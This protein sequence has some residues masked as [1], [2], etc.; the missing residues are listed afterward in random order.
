M[1]WIVGMQR[2]INY[3]EEHLTEDVDFESV[4]KESFSSV[5]HFQR[6]FSLLCGYTLGE[7]IRLRRLSLAGTEL[8]GGKARVI[9]VAL[10][11]GYDSPDSFAKAFQ[12]FHGITPSEARIDGKVLKSF[13]RLSIKISLEGGSAMNYR[14]E[15]K[16]AFEIIERAEI[17]STENGENL[18]T[19]PDFWARAGADGTIERL[20]KLTNDDKY[21][22]GICYGTESRT[23]K[24]FKYSALA[25][26]TLATNSVKFLTPVPSGVM[27]FLMSSNFSIGYAS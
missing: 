25:L 16:E 20:S 24:S 4:A 17:H 7:Y 2:A 18:N 13:S 9:D 14:I 6:V 27:T 5:Y 3:I 12:K 21:I 8:A 10:K 1:N 11:Y 22:F 15:E 26:M 23:E 19:I